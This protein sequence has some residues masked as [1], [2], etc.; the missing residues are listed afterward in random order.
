MTQ[1]FRVC[2]FDELQH[3]KDRNPPWIKL[4]NDMLDDYEFSCLQDASKL[5]LICIWLLASRTDN[6]IPVDPDWIKE[7]ISAKNPVDLDTLLQTKFLEIIE[8]NQPLHNME[9]DA[10][11]SLS[12]CK[13]SARPEKRQRERQSRGKFIPPGKQEVV[14]FFID[15]GY[16]EQSGKSAFEYYHEGEWKDSKGKPVK[17]W[18]Q[19]MRGVWFKTENKTRDPSKGAV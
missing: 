14:Q 3:Y 11:N 18:K 5:H 6:K 12:Q 19:K 7:K 9:Q 15:N 17:N 4:Y 1:Y 8:E 10:S 16:S 2:N 13:Q